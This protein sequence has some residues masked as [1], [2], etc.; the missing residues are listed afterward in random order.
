V[1]VDGKPFT[2]VGI[3]GRIPFDVAG[4]DMSAFMTM[5]ALSWLQGGA[6]NVAGVGLRVGSVAEM[7]PVTHTVKN[8]LSGL[9]VISITEILAAFSKSSWG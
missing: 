9:D 7:Q 5:E 4:H 8:D 6:D 2:V 3:W 1:L